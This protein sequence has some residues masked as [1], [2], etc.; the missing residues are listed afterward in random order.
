M[1]IIENKNKIYR[2]YNRKY[3]SNTLFYK[4]H[5]YIQFLL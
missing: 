2:K 4:W 1:K 3:K 5:R